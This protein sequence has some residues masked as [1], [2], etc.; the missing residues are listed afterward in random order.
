MV[1]SSKETKKINHQVINRETNI[2]LSSEDIIYY[3]END[4]FLIPTTFELMDLLYNKYKI[5]KIVAIR[6]IIG[7]FCCP[8]FHLSN[9]DK[10]TLRNLYSKIPVD[11]SVT[12]IILSKETRTQKKYCMTIELKIIGLFL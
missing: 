10:Q 11:M 8:D 3:V 2:Y 7:Q 9:Y 4:T 1:S 5:K 6:L 12:K